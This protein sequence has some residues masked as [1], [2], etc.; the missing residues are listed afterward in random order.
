MAK[1][2]D[3]HLSAG[4][5]RDGYTR[6]SKIVRHELGF[7]FICQDVYY[8]NIKYKDVIEIVYWIQYHDQTFR[9]IFQN[10]D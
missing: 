7:Y 4:N 10:L 2:L 3:W 1:Q 9:Q 5:G 8:F 6:S